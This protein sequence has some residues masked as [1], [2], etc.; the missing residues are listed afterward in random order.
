MVTQSHKCVEIE[1]YARCV[2]WKCV[3]TYK[4]PTFHPG[5]RDQNSQRHLRPVSL[6]RLAGVL[7]AIP[8]VSFPLLIKYIRL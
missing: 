1:I 2:M 3:A 7:L 5:G 4:L 8:A 6:L